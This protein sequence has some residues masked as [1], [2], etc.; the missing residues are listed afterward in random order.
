MVGGLRRAGPRNHR[1]QVCVVWLPRGGRQPIWRARRGGQEEIKSYFRALTE[2]LF[3]FF[4]C[5]IMGAFI[6]SIPHE[7]NHKMNLGIAVIEKAHRP[8]MVIIISDR[9]ARVEP[10][11]SG[12]CAVG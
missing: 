2:P 6:T 12:R 11:T 1:K 8:S 4:R 9:T 5:Y 3:D 10:R 7:W